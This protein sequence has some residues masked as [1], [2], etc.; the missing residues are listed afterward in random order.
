MTALP[1]SR[2]ETR[3]RRAAMSRLRPR[4]ARMP[5]GNAI[6]PPSSEMA[7]PIRLLPRSTPR[8]RTAD[9]VASRAPGVRSRAGLSTTRCG[10]IM[11]P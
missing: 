11:R 1:I 6:S 8:I 2:S 5:A 7:R 3:A 10:P 4:L 9:S